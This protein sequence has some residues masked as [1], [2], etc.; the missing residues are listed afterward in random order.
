MH[1]IAILITT[2]MKDAIMYKTVQSIVDN[3]TEDC[4]VLIADQGY[5]SD[6]KI[7]TYDYFK[8]QIPCEVFYLPFD[9]GLSYARNYLVQKA[10]DMN[11]PYVL[12]GADSIQ[13]L[14]KY[15]FN[16]IITF[17]EQESY[18][19]V[20]GFEL[21]GSKCP[22][23]YLM[24]LDKNGIHFNVS[25]EITIFQGIKYKKV[26]ICRNIFLAKTDTLIGLWDNEM[27]LAEHEL[28]FLEYKKRG[29]S[30]HWTDSIIFKKCSGNTSVEYQIYRKRFSDFQKI[31]KQKL[32]ISTW[33]TY[34]PDVM[35]EIH[36]YQA[37]HK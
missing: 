4:V 17:L 21:N 30:V 24:S 23:E 15:D 25:N 14:T 11:L 28:A 6:E 9:C 12:M 34:S 3:Y 16:P 36:E 22:W 35:K 1:K 20:V 13:F 8:S 10:H 5:Q 26:D 37:K 29:Y 31:L 32:G 33:V 19:G 7:I 18:R 27:K 2:F